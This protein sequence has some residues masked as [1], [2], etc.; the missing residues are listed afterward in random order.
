LPIT[1]A[2]RLLPSAWACDTNINNANPM[3]RKR[4]IKYGVLHAPLTILSPLIF[5][6]Q[7]QAKTDQDFRL[8]PY[9]A[10]GIIMQA[11]AIDTSYRQIF[12]QR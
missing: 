6:K 2:K 5:N 3:V 12:H 10:T 8:T 9:I 11:S 7:Y 4:N 1:K